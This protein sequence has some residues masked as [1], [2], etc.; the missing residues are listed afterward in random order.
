[1]IDSF[2][3]S[4]T[5]F[6]LSD[7]SVAQISSE[8]VDALCRIEV[9]V[10]NTGLMSGSEVVQLYIS[11]PDIG[12]INP[13][14]QLKGFSKARD[15]NPGQTSKVVINLDKYAFSYWDVRKNGWHAKAGKYQIY[16]GQSSDSL[17][18]HQTFELCQSLVWS[19]L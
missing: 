2:G 7:L 10:K 18:L 13:R 8:D 15:L 1:M 3:L 17:P 16:V 9:T 4:Y 11:F 14:L 19:G 12:L 5:T 6:Q